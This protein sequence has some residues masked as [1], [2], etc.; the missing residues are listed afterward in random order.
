MLQIRCQTLD[1]FQL[2]LGISS[3]FTPDTINEGLKTPKIP[4]EEDLELKAR[5]KS[6]AL[7]IVLVLSSSETNKATEKC[8][9]KKNTVYLCGT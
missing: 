7:I 4:M 6:G 2:I 1:L 9:G 8:G 5:N 3:K